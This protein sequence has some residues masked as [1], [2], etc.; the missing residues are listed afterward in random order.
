LETLVVSDLHLTEAQPFEPRRPFW[1]AHKRRQH[2][3]DDDFARL[4]DHAGRDQ[5][6]PTEL[7]LNGDIFDFDGVME[8]PRDA[9]VRIDWLAR[10]RGLGSEEWMSLFKLECI[11]RDHPDF[12]AALRA[13]IARGHRVVFVLGNHDV[14]L[15]WPSVQQRI[16]AELGLAVMAGR[17]AA[18]ALE[19]S[20]DEA[21]AV[22]EGVERAA[23]EPRHGPSSFPPSA[24]DGWMPD[25]LPRAEPVVFCA[26]FYLSGGDTYVSHGSQY[27]PNC[28]Q[29]SPIHPL[30]EVRGRP[31]VRIPFGDL[32]MRYML[33]G[34]GY[35]NPHA[36]ENYI[37]TA[38]QY[39]RF[40]FRYVVTTQP[41][42]LW[43]WL[44]SAVVTFVVGLRSHWRPAMRDPLLIEEKVQAIAWR[45]QVAPSVVRKLNEVSVASAASNPLRILRELWLDRALL[46]GAA[47]YGGWQLVL[48][49]NI[50]TPISPLWAFAAVALSLPP[51]VLYASSVN[52]TVFH[53]PLLTKERARL[54]SAITGAER[55]VFGHTHR[56]GRCIVGPVEYLNGGF[57]SPAFSD[58]RCARRV[59][60][61]TYVHIRPKSDGPGRDAA[62]LE[63][64]PGGESPR[65]LEGPDAP[66]CRDEGDR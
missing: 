59:G 42:L 29:K 35:F 31:Q 49:V 39:A 66:R 55:V 2:F 13:F 43:S 10:L 63:W 26:W 51:F 32:A 25:S 7:V 17:G 4:L 15:H 58:P 12:F 22:G 48:L 24:P 23:P 37:M 54:I 16:R 47:V 21:E 61:Q 36:T 38:G 5:R 53:Q 44:W 18:R 27:D 1:M 8:L 50:A 65:L 3:V 28:V 46:L 62:L 30:I 56:P 52:P 64:P 33:N 45:A 40:F 19:R 34:M 6:G 11:I 20:D 9:G 57:W 41:L 14:E 60:T